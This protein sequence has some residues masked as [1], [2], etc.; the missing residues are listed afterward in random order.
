MAQLIHKCT[1]FPSC[2]ITLERSPQLSWLDL[3]LCII[4][5]STCAYGNVCHMAAAIYNEQK[6][7]LLL[8]RQMA[9]PQG[10]RP[11]W[12]TPWSSYCGKEEKGNGGRGRRGIEG[13]GG[14][15]TEGGGGGKWREGRGG[16][17]EGKGGRGRREREKGGRRKKDGQYNMR[18][19]ITPSC[20]KCYSRLTLTL[21]KHMPYKSSSLAFFKNL[22]TASCGFIPLQGERKGKTEGR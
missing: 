2:I 17:R 16:R 8:S 18:L 12:Y 5:G 20:I 3:T 19:K 7:I 9:T 15:R 1:Y 11:N 6:E 14:K 13:I 21:W 10:Q 22:L 4:D